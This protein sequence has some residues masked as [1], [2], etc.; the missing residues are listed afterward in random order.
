MTTTAYKH[1]QTCRLLLQR[2]L[3]VKLGKYEIVLQVCP[4][5]SENRMLPNA[6]A[7]SL[8]GT[9]VSAWTGNCYEISFVDD[10][11]YMTHLRMGMDL[12]SGCHLDRDGPKLWMSSGRG[13][14]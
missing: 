6:S 7:N 4:H 12:N 10:G 8:P 9:K 1:I 11:A 14:V 13:W 5:R 2:V 3:R